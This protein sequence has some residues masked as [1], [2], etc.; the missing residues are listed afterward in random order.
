[1]EMR[2]ITACVICGKPLSY[3]RELV[4]TCGK[5]CAKVQLRRQRIRNARIDNDEVTLRSFGIKGE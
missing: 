3:P 5:R 4:D 1:M 2:D